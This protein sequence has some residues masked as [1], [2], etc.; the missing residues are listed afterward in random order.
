MNLIATRRPAPG[1]RALVIVDVDVGGARIFNIEVCRG[2]D[3]G[4]RAWAP[5]RRGEHVAAFTPE[6]ARE[7]GSTALAVV[8]G[9]AAH[10]G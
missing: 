8:G 6:L 3:G 5:R 4:L 10:A 2:P 1:S 7:I 9:G